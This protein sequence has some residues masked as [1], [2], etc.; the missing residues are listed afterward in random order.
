MIFL[1]IAKQMIRILCLTAGF[2]EGHNSAAKNIRDAL[3]WLGPPSVRVEIHDPFRDQGRSFADLT[4]GLYAALANRFPYLW[5]LFYFAS[6]R[7]PW[8]RTLPRFSSRLLRFLDQ[9]LHESEPDAVVSTYPLC[10]FYLQELYRDGRKKPFCHWTVVTDCA[11]LHPIWSEAPTDYFLVPEKET[12]AYL[13]NVG[14]PRQKILVTGFPVPIALAQSSGRPAPPVGEG[15]R[16]RILYILGTG[17]KGAGR[18]VNLLAQKKDWTITIVCGKNVRWYRRLKARLADRE[19]HLE[20]LGWTGKIAELLLSHHVVIGKAGGALVQEALAARRPMIVTQVF[21]GQE[22]GNVALLQRLGVGF[23]APTPEKAVHHLEALFENGGAKWTEIQKR[24]SA[25]PL[26]DGALRIAQAILGQCHR[27]RLDDQS[28]LSLSI[29]VPQSF[30]HH[31]SRVLLVDLHTHSTFS[32]GVL[33]LSQL[34]DFYGAHGFDCLCVTDHLVDPKVLLGRLC[35]LSGLVLVP[36]QLPD[37][38]AAI[39]R[40]KRRAWKEYRLVLLAGVE[41]NKDG[42]S[43]KSSA[44]LLGVDLKKP[45]D[46]SLELEEIVAHVHEQGGLAIASHPHKFQSVWGKDTLYF[47]ENQERFAPILDAWEIANRHELFTPIALKKLPFVANSDFHKP[48]HI[49][50]WKTLLFCEKDPEAIKASVRENQK[51]AITLY[52]GPASLAA[53]GRETRPLESPE[54]NGVFAIPTDRSS[55]LFKEDQ[56]SFS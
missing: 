41:F 5:K 20:V 33:T 54:R 39:E 38:F 3:V 2:G 14:V 22:E 7:L 55:A 42:W 43:A 47:W 21:P 23:Q 10:N 4:E 11:P 50:S 29:S 40:E 56:S 8:Y 1:N 32:D 35:R 53:M 25:A 24:W 31:K 46:P 52:R 17:W 48:K 18:M 28:Q 26:P 19:P 27:Q 6:A 30:A 37:Y 9:L 16:P 15:C 13:E 34:V 51:L 12:A 45:I 44:H 49:Y 36:A